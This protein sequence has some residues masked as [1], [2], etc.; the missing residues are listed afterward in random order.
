MT[1]HPEPAPTWVS[2]SRTDHRSCPV[3]ASTITSEI[4][5]IIS[6]TERQQLWARARDGTL[7][8]CRCLSGHEGLVRAPLLL[9]DPGTGVAMHSASPR[10]SL[11]RVAVDRAIL[12]ELL[13]G[14]LGSAEHASISEVVEVPREV[15]PQILASPRANVADFAPGVDATPELEEFYAEMNMQSLETALTAGG[16]EPGLVAAV[17]YELALQ[18]R[19]RTG[20]QAD[21]G[22]R[23]IELLHRAL[24]FYDRASFPARWAAV[25]SELAAAYR[26]RA[27]GD[28]ASNLHE[29]IRREE[30]ALDVFT[31]ERYPEDFAGSQMNLANALL[32]SGDHSPD[33]VSRAINAYHAALVVFTPLT[34]AESWALAQTNLATALYERGSRDDLAAASQALEQALR[35]RTEEQ[36]PYERA[37]SQMTLGVVLR[38]MSEKAGDE[39]WVRAVA[40][41][42]RAHEVLSRMSST[43]EHLAAAKN[44]GETLMRSPERGDLEESIVLLR[45]VRGLLLDGGD[46]KATDE[47]TRDMAHAWLQLREATSTVQERYELGLLSTELFDQECDLEI[48][49]LVHHQASLDFVQTE[50]IPAAQRQALAKAAVK[51]ALVIFRYKHDAERRAKALA[52]LGMIDAQGYRGGRSEDKAAARAAFEAAHTIAMRLDDSPER[53]ELVGHIFM[54]LT[55]LD[56]PDIPGNWR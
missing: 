43:A 9:F 24:R 11:D 1:T 6:R 37:L 55:A 39:Y 44:L 29:S 30:L 52:Q 28:R 20:D 5:L 26:S 7:H 45:R 41:L 2:T 15:L 18:L 13:D 3:C 27:R 40:S 53:N 46:R 49:G 48:V 31:V 19:T 35:V 34:Y 21:P 38:S 23:G 47:C 12:L 42:R 56:V 17:A 10:E 54:M 36:D 16:L 8:R 4:W 51:R 32:D 14:A 50:S 25:Q 33:T 22:D